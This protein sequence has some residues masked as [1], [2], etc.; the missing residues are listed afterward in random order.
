VPLT[1]G[2][3]VLTIAGGVTL[4]PDKA[5]SAV[6]NSCDTD[7]L[8]RQAQPGADL[9]GIQTAFTIVGG[10]VLIR[11]EGEIAGAIGVSGGTAAQDRDC[12]RAG[13]ELMR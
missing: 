6:A 10:G 1:Q 2:P 4:A 13:A 11:C 5:F 12:A 3:A 9:Y 7:E 8:A